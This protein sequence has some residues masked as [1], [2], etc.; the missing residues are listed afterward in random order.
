MGSHMKTT[1]EIADS[2]LV[3]AKAMADKEGKTLRSLIEEALRTHIG[4]RARRTP[5]RLRKA[6]FKG[7]GV[8][9]GLVEGRWQELR[10]AIYE[11]R[12]A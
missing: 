11:G 8:R 1:I 3:E 2:L 4:R 7:R 12:G 6:S 5:F 10:D 9:K